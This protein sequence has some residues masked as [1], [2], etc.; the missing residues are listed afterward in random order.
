MSVLIKTVMITIAAETIQLTHILFTRMYSVPCFMKTIRYLSK[1]ISSRYV[2]LLL[3]ISM[4]CFVTSQQISRMSESIQ[5]Q[6]LL[7]IHLYDYQSEQQTN[8]RKMDMFY[9]Q[10]WNMVHYKLLSA[11]IILF[12]SKLMFVL[13][14]LLISISCSTV[15]WKVL[16]GQGITAL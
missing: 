1:Q 13:F 6:T 8:N 4:N 16:F 5:K 11:S 12:M 3:W 2:V 7:C 15:R 10:S 9:A 14:I